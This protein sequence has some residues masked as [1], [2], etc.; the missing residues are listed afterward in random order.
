M[1]RQPAFAEQYCA[2]IVD[3]VS[4]G[5]AR[6]LSVDEATTPHPKMWYLPHFGVTNPNKLGKLRLVFNAAAKSGGTSLND[7]L[8]T[9]PDLLN[10]LTGILL[11]FRERV[12]RFGGDIKEMF[13]QV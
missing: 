8:L 2:K 7:A 9:G 5:Y 1:D 13:H 11:K 3:Y 10:P 6:K 12:I 4:Q